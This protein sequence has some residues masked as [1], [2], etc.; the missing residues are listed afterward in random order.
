MPDEIIPKSIASP[1]LLAH[2]LTAKFADALPFYRQEKQFSRIGIDLPWSTICNWAI[3][4]ADACKIILQMM[5]KDILENPVIHI[6]E[7]P[8]Q[9]LKE[10][11]RIKSYM[12]AFKGSVRGKPTVLFEYHPSRSGDV[13]AAFLNGYQGIVQ[14]EGYAGYD[15]LCEKKLNPS[16]GLLELCPPQ[17]RGG[18]QRESEHPHREYRD[19]LKV[20]QQAV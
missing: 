1:G 6:D 16:C 4:T 10:P 19:G 7:A 18:P 14:T 20:Y 9:A 2:L 3:K 11:G 15:F 12:W 5:K 8:I 13:A 17:I